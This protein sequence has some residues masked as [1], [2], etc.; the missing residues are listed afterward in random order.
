M[1]FILTAFAFTVCMMTTSCGNNDTTENDNTMDSIGNPSSNPSST[2]VL[3]DDSL[4][5][6]GT[7]TSL[8]DSLKH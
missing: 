2:S 3:T 7:D 6:T 1:K 4:Q 8:V 5:S